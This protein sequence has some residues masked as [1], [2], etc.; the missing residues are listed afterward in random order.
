MWS[1]F[2]FPVSRHPRLELVRQMV[3]LWLIIWRNAWLFLSASPSY[4]TS[5]S[6]SHNHSVSVETEIRS[7]KIFPML[8]KNMSFDV[9]WIALS[10]L[11]LK[12][13]Y[14]F[15]PFTECLLYIIRESK[16]L[17]LGSHLI[18]PNPYRINN[19]ILQLK[20]LNPSKLSGAARKLRSSFGQRACFRAWTLQCH[21]EPLLGVVLRN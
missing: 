16:K 21:A 19:S 14:F 3:A 11:V 7:Q 6:E 17:H 5:M 9:E 12:N 18:F 13:S 2:S 15:V 20:I 1:R 8:F 4:T 10:Q